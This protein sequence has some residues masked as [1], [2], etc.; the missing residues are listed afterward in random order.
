MPTHVIV[1]NPGHGYWLRTEAEDGS[2]TGSDNLGPTLPGAVQMADERGT[3]PT[4][5]IDELG[6]L[7]RIPSG[8]RRKSA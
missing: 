5:W 4:H 6:I 7:M 2:V 1:K 8:I 3:P